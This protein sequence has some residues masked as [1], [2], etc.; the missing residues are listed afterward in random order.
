MKKHI[1]HLSVSC[2]C[3]MQLLKQLKNDID[4]RKYNMQFIRRGC[5][6]VDKTHLQ[7][8]ARQSCI[9]TLGNYS[10]YTLC[11]SILVTSWESASMCIILRSKSLSN[12]FSVIISLSSKYIPQEP[13]SA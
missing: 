3:I 10:S 2:K 1:N 9:L 11:S 8:M 12:A 13:S 5:L 4:Q 6:K 7:K